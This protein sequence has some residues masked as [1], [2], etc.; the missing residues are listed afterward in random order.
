MHAVARGTYIHYMIT[1]DSGIILQ[2][3]THSCVTAC[4][5]WLWLVFRAE[6]TYAYAR[7]LHCT[8]GQL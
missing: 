8:S 5:R 7:T 3:N 1:K 6:M 4:P 2:E